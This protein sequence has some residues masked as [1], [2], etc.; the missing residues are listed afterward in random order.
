MID[1][2]AG[3]LL[4]HFPQELLCMGFPD[5]RYPCQFF[6]PVAQKFSTAT[7]SSGLTPGS[8]IVNKLS[9][10]S[11]LHHGTPE[12]HKVMP[13]RLSVVGPWADYMRSVIGQVAPA[14]DIQGDLYKNI[15]LGSDYGF[16]GT[17]FVITN[18]QL[19]VG[20]LSLRQALLESH[21]LPSGV[22]KK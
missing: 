2:I 21:I 22:C 15:P 5:L 3:S 9:M 12:P 4:L 13:H 14:R 11:K 16:Q 8:H 19:L 6:A 17:S 20:S 7:P 10:Q 1:E 18:A